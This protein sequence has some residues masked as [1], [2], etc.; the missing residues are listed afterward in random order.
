MLTLIELCLICCA[1][2]ENDVAGIDVNCGCPK[3]FSLKGNMGAALLTQPEKLCSILTTLVQGLAIP[4]TC[5]IRLLPTMDESLKL[6]K[7]I[8]ST[9]VSAIGVH[10]RTKPERPQHSCR[11]EEIKQIVS[12]LNNIPVIAK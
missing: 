1:D 4:V 8:E 5:K 9:G 6:V 2:S 11:V 3:E 7:M 12:V 10:G